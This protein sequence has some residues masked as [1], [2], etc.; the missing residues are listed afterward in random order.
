MKI[1]IYIVTYKNEDYL[2]NNIISLLGSDLIN[3]KYEINV[4][5]N[6]TSNFSLQDFCDTNNIKVIHNNLRPDFSTGHLSR[7]WNQAIIN[8]FKDINNPDCDILVL[9]QN[10]NIF[11]KDW[12]QYIIEK[13]KTYDF[14]SIG[15]G[16]Q[17]HSYTI[18]HIKK[19]GI[20]DE[21]YCNI[22][23][24]EADYFIRSYLYNKERTSINDYNHK[25]IHNKLVE[26][27][28]T[29]PSGIIGTDKIIELDDS[30][31]GGMRGDESHI[32]SS[33]YHYISK[34]I[35]DQKWGIE[36]EGSWSEEKLKHLPRN[37]KISSFIFYPYFEKDIED[38]NEKGYII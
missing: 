31:K 20:W 4:I 22:G 7:N 36:F 32:Q 12:C 37:S 38:L 18:N 1:K 3:Y 19:V 9:C 15:G 5:N 16:D 33:R 10:D 29:T 23:Y 34:K 26:Q 2:K 25:R 13:H 35:L 21:R 27:P 24:Q 11:K 28:T 8:G 14:I 6:F 17:Y 30:L